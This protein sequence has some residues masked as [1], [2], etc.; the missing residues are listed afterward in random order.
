MTA[1][2]RQIAFEE[3]RQ[4]EAR[5]A[6]ARSMSRLRV[7]GESL[8]EFPLLIRDS[9]TCRRCGSRYGLC[10]HTE[11]QEDHIVKMVRIPHENTGKKIGLT[12]SREQAWTKREVAEVKRLSA[13][14]VG[15]TDIGNML[16]RSKNSVVAK[17]ARMRAK[18]DVA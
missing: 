1:N 10:P 12:G 17:L 16:G 3:A 15:P 14:G 11:G 4:R 5:F 13:A 6:D 2:F 7:V 9:R 8:N 18:G